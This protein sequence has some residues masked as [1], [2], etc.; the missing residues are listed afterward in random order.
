MNPMG[1]SSIGA[2][3]MSIGSMEKSPMAGPMSIGKMGGGTPPG[4]RMADGETMC[5]NC[6]HFTG[7]GCSKFSNYPCTAEQVCDA[8][9]AKAD[10]EQAEMPMGD[11]GSGEY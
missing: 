3:P 5:G 9:E 8:H 2:G 11:E 6:A 7:Q 4:L 10:A 1:K